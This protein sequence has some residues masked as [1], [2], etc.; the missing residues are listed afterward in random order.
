MFVCPQCPPSTQWCVP[1]RPSSTSSSSTPSPSSSSCSSLCYSC[2]TKAAAT[3][4]AKKARTA[5]P[6][7]G[8]KNRTSATPPPVWTRP[9]WAYTPGPSTKRA[10]QR[11]PPRRG[12]N[13]GSSRHNAREQIRTPPSDSTVVH[14]CVE[15]VNQFNNFYPGG[16][17]ICVFWYACVD[18]NVCHFSTFTCTCA[19]VQDERHIF[20]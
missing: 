14:R 12:Q 7:C 2:A 20:V 1:T 15:L 16:C 9:R 5:P 11:P 8:L 6:S 4:R 19:D 13:R 10:L 18:Q 3:A 17:L